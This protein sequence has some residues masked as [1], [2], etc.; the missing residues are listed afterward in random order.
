[1]LAAHRGAADAAGTDW[2]SAVLQKIEEE[3][4]AKRGLTVGRMVE[5]GGVSRRWSLDILGQECS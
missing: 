1:M 3:M 5:L 2:K 4:S